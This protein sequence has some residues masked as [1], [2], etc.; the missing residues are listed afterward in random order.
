L[1][2]TRTIYADKDGIYNRI[3]VE[4]TEA[5]S[6]STLT[7]LPRY[8]KAE[9]KARAEGLGWAAKLI[10]DWAGE[11]EPEPADEPE[12]SVAPVCKRCGRPIHP[13]RAGM[14]EDDCQQMVCPGVTGGGA[15]EPEPASETTIQTRMVPEQGVTLDGVWVPLELLG[16]LD[17]QGP[18]DSMMGPGG[19]FTGLSRDQE[20][21]LIARELAVK[22]T[23]GGCHRGP[24]LTEFTD[25]LFGQPSKGTS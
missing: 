25:A 9:W 3:M 1:P 16:E 8:R 7:N 6:N 23:R 20:R 4:R 2:L 15:H 13:V 21:V 14:W 19:A 10:C 11:Q 22:E 18:Y 12:P 5:L 24:K 17:S